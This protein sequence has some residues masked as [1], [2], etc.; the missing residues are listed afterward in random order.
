MNERHATESRTSGRWSPDVGS[1]RSALLG[2]AYP[3]RARVGTPV[4]AL[5]VALGMVGGV[6]LCTGN[7]VLGPADALH[8]LANGGDTPAARII[9]VLRL[10]RFVG[11]LLVG[12]SLAVAGALMKG[13]TRNPLA[14]PT[15]TSV[16]SAGSNLPA[17]AAGGVAALVLAIVLAVW[18]GA[19][20]FPLAVVVHALTHRGGAHDAAFILWELRMPRAQLAASGLVLQTALRNPL[21]EPGVIGVTSG[22]TL[23]VMMLLLVANFASRRASRYLFVWGS[24]TAPWAFYDENMTCSLLNLLGGVNVAWR[25]A[26]G[27]T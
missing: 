4:F 3:T 27:V 17:C 18:F 26:A 13:I 24:G 25:P 8:A 16:V 21:A 9:H 19:A 15:L 1:V 2:P 5:I 20:D 12:A 11:A 7:L 14:D 10:P 22:A 6:S 23:G